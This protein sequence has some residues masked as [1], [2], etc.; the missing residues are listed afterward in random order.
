LLDTVLRMV[1]RSLSTRGLS[2]TVVSN[3]R[4]T[5]HALEVYLRGA[6]IAASGTRALE[7]VAEITPPSSTAVI[8]FP[9]E[10]AH[11]V[12]DKALSALRRDRS[13]LLVVVVTHEP[14]RFER[15]AGRAGASGTLVIPKPA[16]AWTI[17]DAVRARLGSSRLPE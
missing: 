3:N 7:Q 10:Y 15:P 17:L 14:H 1:A 4:E 13:R 9:D 5:L 11:A 8:V 6:G 16:W 12:V 2:V